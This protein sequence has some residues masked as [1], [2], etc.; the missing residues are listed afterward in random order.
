MPFV[1]KLNNFFAAYRTLFRVD[2]YIT[3]SRT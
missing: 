1:T 2:A 3:L